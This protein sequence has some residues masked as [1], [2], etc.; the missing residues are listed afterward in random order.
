VNPE[1]LTPYAFASLAV[2]MLLFWWGKRNGTLRPILFARW[3]RWAAFTLFFGSVGG[4]LDPDR[5]LA[6]YLAA[7]ALVWPLLESAWFW[8]LIG[9]FSH[10]GLPPAPRYREATESETE[11][12]LPILEEWKTDLDLVGFRHV[13]SLQGEME[14][15]PW[16]RLLVFQ[17]ETN[18]IRAVVHLFET[19]GPSRPWVISFLTRD[20]ADNLIQT[21]N[22]HLPYGGFLPENCKLVRRPLL[23][24]WTLLVSEHHERIAGI[25]PVAWNEANLLSDVVDHQIEME[26]VNNARGFFN[27][28]PDRQD[29]GLLTSEGRSRLLVELWLLSYLGRN[30]A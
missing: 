26:S 29:A 17:N 21:D 8:F 5:P 1:V 12:Y 16:L 10:S 18:T 13:G 20:E 14:G 30:L 19:P 22:N 27:P 25:S 7:G 28:R 11:D 4:E 23:R 6:V 15:T 3:V 2:W 9:R 24:E